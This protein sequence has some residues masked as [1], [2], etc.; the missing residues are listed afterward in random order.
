MRLEDVSGSRLGVDLVIM[1]AWNDLSG[2]PGRACLITAVVP[3]AEDKELEALCKAADA[4]M[5]VTPASCHEPSAIL[6]SQGSCKL[7]TGCV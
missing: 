7:L 6:C 5:S 3:R 2:G 1:F 4:K